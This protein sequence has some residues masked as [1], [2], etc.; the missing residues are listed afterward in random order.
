MA[1]VLLEIC[2][3]NPTGLAAAVEGGADRI[4][5]CAA[6]DLGGL[7]PSVGLMRAAADCGLPV[8]AL[9][10]PRPGD[11]CYDPDELAVMRADIAAARQAGLAGVVVGAMRGQALD[12]RALA[13]L[14]AAAE[15]LDVTLHRAADLCAD[16]LTVVDTA[17]ALGI[18]R[19]LTSGAAAGA[20]AGRDRLAAMMRHAGGR[21]TVMPGGGLSADTVAALRPLRPA[22]IHASCSIAGPPAPLG[23]GAPRRTDAA[24]V[25]ALK[26]ALLTWGGVPGEPSDSAERHRRCRST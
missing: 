1:E 14:V 11:F 12:G 9:I 10:R 25:R 2:V 6:L 16:P 23:F 21:V 26:A 22:E 13:G 19:I 7:T 17:E 4:E 20:V 8:M 15:G 18:R 3:E 24:R 5:L